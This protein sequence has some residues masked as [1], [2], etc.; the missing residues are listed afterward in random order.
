MKVLTLITTYALIFLCE[1]GD[2]TQIA[3]LLFAS[4]NPT[5]R[6]LIFLG[7]SLALCLCVLLEVTVG[8]HIARFIGANVFNRVTGLVFLLI[9]V[10]TLARLFFP[11]K[12]T[13][14]SR[15][16]TVEEA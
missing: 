9:G 7:A 3:T 13:L 4:N 1:L 8:I 14:S 12:L 5:K 16:T 10:Y 2:K 11:T 15:E 6:W